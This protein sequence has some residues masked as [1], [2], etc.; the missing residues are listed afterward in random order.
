MS[1]KRSVGRC[2]VLVTVVLFPDRNNETSDRIPP[3]QTYGDR[4]R[5][6]YEDIFNDDTV[7]DFMED[8][9][10]ITYDDPPENSD[11]DDLL[12]EFNFTFQIHQKNKEA[13][14]KPSGLDTSDQSDSSL[15]DPK[16]S[17]L[18]L[19]WILRTQNL[20][21]SELFKKFD[22]MTTSFKRERAKYAAKLRAKRETV[23]ADKD[24]SAPK[25]FTKEGRERFAKQKKRMERKH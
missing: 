6:G 16:L 23:E 25:Y 18:S 13:T 5:D 15:P 11:V 10:Q 17:H 1:F 3:R 20:E 2:I 24:H 9:D 19:N 21:R 7:F 4:Y 14:T 12:S 22:T 8:L